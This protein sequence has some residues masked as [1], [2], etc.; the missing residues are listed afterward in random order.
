M[1]HGIE[2]RQPIEILQWAQTCK[3]LHLPLYPISTWHSS[4]SSV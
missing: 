2:L 3:P 1:L 4:C